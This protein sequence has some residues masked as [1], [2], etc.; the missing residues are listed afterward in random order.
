MRLSDCCRVDSRAAASKRLKNTGHSPFSHS[1]GP[2]A[3]PLWHCA[4]IENAVACLCTS[5]NNDRHDLD[6]HKCNTGLWT[7]NHCA[8]PSPYVWYVWNPKP[9]QPSLLRIPPPPTHTHSSQL[10]NA[11]LANG[12][13]RRSGKFCDNQRNESLKNGKTESRGHE[14]QTFSPS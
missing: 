11:M 10:H 1:T 13:P 14:R 12:N 5:T 4:Q 7:A 9:S 8:N 6:T 2:I 3:P